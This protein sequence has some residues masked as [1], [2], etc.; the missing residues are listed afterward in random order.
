MDSCKN[1]RN[2]TTKING[3]CKKYRWWL[4]IGG[5]WE[6]GNLNILSNIIKFCIFLKTILINK[7]FFY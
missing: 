4:Q 5:T 3:F 1:R 6:N 2:I 7:I